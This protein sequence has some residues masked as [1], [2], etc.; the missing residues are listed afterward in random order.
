MSIVGSA[1]PQKGNPMTAYRMSGGIGAEYF[2]GIY[3]DLL[4]KASLSALNYGATQG[5]NYRSNNLIFSLT[6]RGL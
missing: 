4:F 3:K 6:Y 2:Y 1:G 5:A